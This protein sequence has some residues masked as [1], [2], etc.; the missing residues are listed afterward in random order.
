MIISLGRPLL[1]STR[2]VW[3]RTPL[4]PRPVGRRWHLGLHT[5]S[6]MCDADRSGGAS[7]TTS[8]TASSNTR[9]VVAVGR[10]PFASIAARD[11]NGQTEQ[12]R[13]DAVV[14]V[15]R[16]WVRNPGRNYVEGI[17]DGSTHLR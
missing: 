9:P 6:V 11:E 10:H 15:L 13:S 17:S 16:D 8:L 3:L 5:V 7:M 1:T 2:E 4:V 12:T 14:S